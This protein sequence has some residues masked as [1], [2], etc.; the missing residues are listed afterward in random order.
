MVMLCLELDYRHYIF[1]ERKI[2]IPSR[3]PPETRTEWLDSLLESTFI[4]AQLKP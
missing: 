1:W 2:E 3:I 4:R